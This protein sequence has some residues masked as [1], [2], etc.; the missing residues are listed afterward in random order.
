MGE[1]YTLAD[2][3]AAVRRRLSRAQTRRLE[4]S[5]LG[6]RLP[7]ELPAR[8]LLHLVDSLR[9]SGPSAII[10]IP[11]RA[12]VFRAPANDDNRL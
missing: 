10:G 6:R 9:P 4:T 7:T 3:R 5:L 1:I 8:P 12:G 11:R 2:H